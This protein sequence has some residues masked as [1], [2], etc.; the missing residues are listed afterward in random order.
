MEAYPQTRAPHR[1]V[2]RLVGVIY[3]LASLFG[4]LLSVGGLFFLWSTKTVV[5][6]DITDAAD[7]AG[8]T[9][10]ATQRTINVVSDSLDQADND[11]QL[12]QGMTNNVSSALNDSSGLITATAN[13]VGGD[14]ITF[15]D[16][17]R[18]S[19]ASVSSGARFVD[20]FLRVLNGV[21]F[22]G[23]RYKPDVP[24]QD[25]V[26][27]VSKSMEPLP[28]SLTKIRGELD[29]ASNNVDT[30]R[31]QID[32][33]T[34]QLDDVHGSLSN[35]R[36]VVKEYN[37]ILTDVQGRFDRFQTHLP[38]LLNTIYLGLTA[39]L[40]WVVMTQLGL[41]VHGIQLLA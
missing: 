4:L 2:S 10:T 35:A 30:V 8:R 29:T 31:G 3:V 27:N 7:L 22:I 18:T 14:L 25:S 24:L 36:K 12:I 28:G 13:L 26:A 20:D 34:L 32:A 40:A 21:P 15:V 6:G 37:L 38:A 5:V 41:L 11:L 19:L 16:N 23:G 33:L 9:L 39:V 17:T 1:A